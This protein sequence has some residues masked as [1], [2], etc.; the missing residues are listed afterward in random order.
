MATATVTITSPYGTNVHKCSN[1][2]A[3]EMFV[4]ATVGEFLQAGRV[5]GGKLGDWRNVTLYLSGD[6]DV[7]PGHASR[8][9][10]IVTTR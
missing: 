6:R 4:N 10:T 1:L 5:T 3:A 7:A 2:A 8:K 9:I